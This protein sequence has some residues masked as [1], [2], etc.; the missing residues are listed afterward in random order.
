MVIEAGPFDRD[1]DSV[2]IPGSFFPVPYLWLPLPSTPQAALNGRSFNIPA[3][4]V[5]G[6]GSV[7]NAMVCLRP[8]KEELAAWEKLGAN[9]WNWDALLPYYKKVRRSW[10]PARA[11]PMTTQL[12][13]MQSE[14]STAP[15]PDFARSANFSYVD[16]VHGHSGPVQVSFPNFYYP[17][18]GES[19]ACY[20]MFGS[21]KQLTGPRELVRSCRLLRHQCVRG[22]QR[23]KRKGRHLLSFGN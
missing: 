20:L 10:P 17:A 11:G 22:S 7:V 12:T 21:V 5:V 1:E 13:N 23:W 18:S 9:G 14:N 3:A 19:Y 6:G 15:D 8:G 2:L 4:K 16:E